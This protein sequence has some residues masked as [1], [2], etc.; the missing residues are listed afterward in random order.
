MDSIYLLAYPETLSMVTLQNIIFHFYNNASLCTCWAMILQ[1]P[2]EN[3]Y[4]KKTKYILR[5][6]VSFCVGALL[7]GGGGCLKWMYIFI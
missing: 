3:T 7:G 4:W 5:K 2:K 1:K 6:T